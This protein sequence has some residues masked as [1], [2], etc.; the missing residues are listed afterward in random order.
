M[1]VSSDVER[2][3]RL[4]GAHNFRDLGG[5]RGAEGR[6][7]RYGRFYR[8]GVLEHFTD[9]DLV[10][11]RGLGIRT[12][13]DLRSNPERLNHP[14]RWPEHQADEPAVEFWSRD[15]E[16]S[17]GNLMSVATDPA[18]S[19]DDTRR[20]MTDMYRRLPYE[21]APSYRVMFQRIASGATPLVVHCAAGKDR[22]GVAVALMLDIL[23]VSRADI[24][25]DYCL[26]DRFFDGLIRLARNNKAGWSLDGV[27]Q[28]VW[29]PLLRA[30]PVYIAAMFDELEQKHGS[31]AVYLADVVGIRTAEMDAIRGALLV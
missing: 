1:Q 27:P 8:S 5:Y 23:G 16:D 2:M 31:V 28:P 13:C 6:V 17:A 20:V 9:D 14:T 11:L 7:V 22:T 24:T 15:H 30:E 12:I 21:Q 25:A 26:T 3:P 10:R 18:S 4:D 29:E 19:G